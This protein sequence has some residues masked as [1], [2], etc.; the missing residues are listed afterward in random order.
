VASAGITTGAR[1]PQSHSLLALA[2]AFAVA[3]FI[4]LFP[5]LLMV[6]GKV[7]LTGLCFRRRSG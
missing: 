2:N 5:V 7:L 3:L 6:A 1:N 4:A